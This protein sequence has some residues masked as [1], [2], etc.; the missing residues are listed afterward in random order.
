[1][2]GIRAFALLAAFLSLTSSLAHAR[3]TVVEA[4]MIGTDA[5]VPGV[6][7]KWE[8]DGD[9]KGSGHT[10]A[11]GRCSIPGL[12]DTTAWVSLKATADGM[13][14]L[15]TYWNR[16]S[17][18]AA[19]GAT[20][21]A[22]QT[23]VPQRFTFA[24]EKAQK[25]GG[26]VVDDAGKPIADANV[27]VSVSKKYAGS[28]QRVGISW[29]RV[30]TDAQG[31]WSLDG[32]PAEP[33]QVKLAV[34]DLGHLSSMHFETEP[35]TPLKNLFDS[36]AKHV[37]TSGTPVDV[38]VLK[39]DGAPAPGA[40]VFVGRSLHVV[41]K[42]AATKSDDQ[43]KVR[44]GGKPG[45]ANV[46]T[47]SLAGFGP[48]QAVMTIG[49]QPQQI[50]LKLTAPT[51]RTIEVVDS[52][53]KPIRG[54]SVSPADWRSSEVLDVDLKTDDA[55]RAT[56]ADGPAEEVKTRVNAAG[57]TGR[58]DFP[59]KANETARVVL[60]RPTDVLA[61]VVDAESGA[62]I[63]DFHVRA[64]A[65]WNEGERLVWQ[66]GTWLDDEIRKQPGE[67]KL[68]LATPAHQYVLRV[69]APGHLAEDIGPFTPDGKPQTF[70]VRLK[71]APDVAGRVVTADDKPVAG[72]D[73]YLVPSGDWFG[74]SNG[75]PGSEDDGVRGKTDADG[76]FAL[77]AQKDDFALIVFADAGTATLKRS[78]LTSADTV[79]RLAPWA[80][81]RGTILVQGKPAGGITVYGNANPTI[82]ADGNHVIARQY[83]FET[84]KDGT[85]DLPRVFPGPLRLTRDIPNH[86]PGRAWYITLG[87]IDAKPGDDLQVELG[88]GV[89]VTGRLEIPPGKPWM[90]RQSRAEPKGKPHVEG[91]ENVEVLDD[92]RFRIDGLSPGEYT[93]HVA[94]HEFPPENSCGWGRVV[95]EFDKDFTVSTGAQ[96]FD[97]GNVP[98]SPIVARLL[99]VGD[100]PPDFTV[101]ML[102]G[103]ELQLTKLKGK[104][105][106][107]DFWAT[108]CAPCI[109]E[110][111]NLQK[112]VD[113]HKGDSRFVVVSLSI[114][115]SGDDLTRFVKS[116]KMTWPQARIGIES[117]TARDYGATAVPLT[118]LI[119]P[120]GRLLARD[121][122][123]DELAKAAKSALAK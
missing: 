108:W 61:R 64:G 62:T 96:A 87:V 91:L 93:M 121:L 81:V 40:R 35:Y 55:G 94:L 13:V 52:A 54:A 48:A 114:D 118:F 68:T 66:S 18:K 98:P 106:L 105:V 86:A 16:P 117:P 57:F 100:V 12:T 42:F 75:K 92:G 97:I 43:G 76:R 5:P 58:R 37:L 28:E 119:G 51:P 123:G 56:W 73:V 70:D 7:I 95:G 85:F 3:E 77:P 109:A 79:I 21:Q 34:Y 71:P 89:A 33:T 50:T 72:A 6:T 60:V 46:V 19:A 26:R 116:M 15:A 63:K 23:T 104:V 110:I 24:I 112:V 67:F 41:N 29:K 36:K 122:R 47:A 49:A 103:S 14:P 113:T 102:D 45:L 11:D 59:W 82:L 38:T 83:N 8:A 10:D 1:M 20:T 78:E 53:G 4:R 80:R 22:T 115:E 120:D 69:S 32:V 74:T 2:R 111:P 99:K 84:S 27:I 101:K 107:V 65:A 31:V 17:P 90:I 30:T 9:V 88:Q 25:I 44:L 39:P